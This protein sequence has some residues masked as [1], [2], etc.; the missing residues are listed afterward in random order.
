M[1][2]GAFTPDPW[3]LFGL[4]D[5]VRPA[6][7]DATSSGSA[8]ALLTVFAADGGAP[9]GV[10]AQMLVTAAGGASGYLAGGCVEADAIRHALA[11]VADGAP[12]TLTYGVGGP[13]DLPLACGGRIEVLAERMGADDRAA[14]ALARSL[15][16]RAPVIL[17]T[18]GAR[19]RCVAVDRAEPRCVTAADDAGV[20]RAPFEIWRRYDPVRRL[21][22]IGSD[23]TALALASL[24]MNS[25][26][27]TTLLRPLG[28][29]TPSPIA[30]VAYR[31]EPAQQALRALDLDRWT[32]VVSATHDAEADVEAL[33]GA[34]ASD[35]FYVAAVGSP[36]RAPQIR[37]RLIDRGLSRDVVARLRIPAGL[38]IG[39]HAPGDIAI[40]ILAELIETD[41]A[42]RAARR[43]VA[44]QA[45]A[46]T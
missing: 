37:G 14:E 24:A 16:T 45:I 3:P 2:T 1:S 10:G 5:D 6:L 44:G 8:C 32:A 25:G 46:A 23:P 22:V 29:E 21:V 15:A 43:I 4:T 42:T 27:E 20:R 17:Q 31:R 35:A 33:A 7:A 38:P 18:D 28:P 30:G 41:R 12:R 9:R 26:L 40:S 11:V 19:R 13:P 36:R 39:G 34:L